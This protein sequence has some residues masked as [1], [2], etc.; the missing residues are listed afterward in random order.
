MDKV[1]VYLSL[2]REE[3]LAQLTEECSEAAQAA[4]KLR[5]AGSG[6][7][8]TPVSEE[9]A[10]HKLI[11]EL[12]DVSSA[13]VFCLAASLKTTTRG[14]SAKR[15]QTRSRTLRA[16]SSTAGG[17]VCWRDP[18]QRRS[19]SRRTRKMAKA[20][21]IDAVALYEQIAAEVSSML[22]QPP[23]II[24]SKI[25][26]MVLQAPTIGS[27][28]VK[29]DVPDDRFDAL[30]APWAR[31]IRAAFPAAFVNMY[32]ELIL[33]PKA[34]MYIM[35]N[36]VRDERDFKAA[37]LEDCSRNA[38][39]GCSRKLQDEH[40]D[41][42][43]KLLDTKFTRDDIELIYTYLGNGIQ[44]DLCLRF[45]ASGYDLEVLREYDKKQEAGRNGKT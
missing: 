43:N 29:E 33:I 5:R 45:V 35:L 6:E 20:R 18:W 30:A 8:P 36:Q 1:I 12:A 4:L 34:N 15:Y 19:R 10:F 32:N 37:V 9:D 44:H 11:E 17:T 38:F 31:K 42:I 25:M 2:S 21:A 27:S 13:Q 41:G 14:T 22:K 26:A 23:G 3:L 16:K 39:K 24:V 7:N 28:E 40:L